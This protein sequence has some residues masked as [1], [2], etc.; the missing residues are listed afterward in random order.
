MI[1]ILIKTGDLFN[2]TG[3]RIKLLRNKFDFKKIIFRGMWLIERF[4]VPG[5]VICRVLTISFGRKNYCTSR[6]IS[7]RRQKLEKDPLQEPV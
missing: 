6:L 2:I 1:P 3:Y 7:T 4:I 5:W